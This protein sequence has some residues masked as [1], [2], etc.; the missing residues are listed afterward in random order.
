[1]QELVLNMQILVT[2]A[3][4]EKRILRLPDKL[5]KCHWTIVAVTANVSYVIKIR[6]KAATLR[7]ALH[8]ESNL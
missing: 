5:E 4:M 8:L 7:G 6:M 3:Y 1:M 2:G